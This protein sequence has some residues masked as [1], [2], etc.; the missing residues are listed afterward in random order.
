MYW[1]PYWW[2]FGGI[3]DYELGGVYVVGMKAN[4]WDALM[5][6]GFTWEAAETIVRLYAAREH[7]TIA[8]RGG[9]RRRGDK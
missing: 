5:V 1:W 3:I 9:D 6:C 7:I 8:R 2:P 4:P